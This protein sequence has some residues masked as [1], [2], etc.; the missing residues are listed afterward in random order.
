MNEYL[1][2]S[3][4]INGIGILVLS[5]LFYFPELDW[6]YIFILFGIIT[7]IWNHGTTF[8]LAK[9][10]DRIYMIFSFFFFL[11]FVATIVSKNDVWITI[12]LLCT[13]CVFYLFSKC[14]R[15]L[16]ISSILHSIC[17]FLFVCF[18]GMILLDKY[19]SDLNSKFY[20]VLEH[21]KQKIFIEK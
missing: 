13:M 4:Y 14:F 3:S 16:Y 7:S 18:F 17:H 12:L 2:C 11:F 8:H 21:M 10:M 15:N 9:W 20:F 6:L 1:L 19:H 5:I